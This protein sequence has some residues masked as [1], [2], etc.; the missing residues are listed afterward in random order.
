MK[1]LL[2]YIYLLLS[3]PILASAASGNKQLLRQLDL[4]LEQRGRRAIEKE[5]RVDS[6]K[7]IAYALPPG[8]QLLGLYQELYDEYY[9]YKFDSAVVYNEKSIALAQQLH[10][11]YNEDLCRI[12]RSELFALGG[13][14]IESVYNIMQMDEE[15]FSRAGMNAFDIAIENMLQMDTQDLPKSLLFKFHYTNYIL[16]LYLEEYG[17]NNAYSIE[18]RDRKEKHLRLAIENMDDDMPGAEFYKG[19]YYGN[20][21]R[22]NERALS[23]YFA[24]VESGRGAPSRADAMSLFAIASIY[25][26]RGDVD[27]YEEFLIR[28]C[29]VDLANNVKENMAL[30]KLAVLLFEQDEDNVERAERYISLSMEDARFYDSRLRIIESSRM[31]PAILAAYHS[32]LEK[33]SFRLQLVIYGISFLAIWLLFETFFYVKQNKQLSVKRN[34]LSQSNDSLTT[35]NRKLEEVNAR[36]IDTNHRRERLAKLYIDLCADY[37]NKLKNYQ[38]LVKRKVKANQAAE[39]LSAAA[40]SK[41]S[42]HDAASFL[43][44]FDKAFLD[45]YPTFVEELNTLLRTDA[46]FDMTQRSGLTPELRIFALIRLGIRESSEIASLLFLSPQTVYNYRSMVKGRA[47]SRET[48]E[49][50]VRRLC[51]IL[52]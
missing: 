10:D 24:Q 30:Q 34:E 1:T 12:Q 19:E 37:I 52:Q 20:V 16:N 38:T 39:L 21:V 43:S 35:L 42:E 50:D 48:F 11:T 40:S 17:D 45:L 14:Y 33:K 23:H 18:F 27:R 26:Q 47:V 2:I 28:S 13:R 46:R 49:D 31:L 5:R 41:L 4:A 44:Q 7:Q 25:E 8:E 9:V 29:L 22:D 36:L 6:L 51:T 3:W 32:L 15:D